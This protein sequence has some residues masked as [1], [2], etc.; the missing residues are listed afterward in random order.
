MSYHYN[1]KEQLD[2]H[3]ENVKNQVILKERELQRLINL[4]EHE[5]V[6]R[7]HKHRKMDEDYEKLSHYIKA[8]GLDLQKALSAESKEDVVRK[9]EIIELKSLIGRANVKREMINEE[10]VD[11]QRLLQRDEK[12]IENIKLLYSHAAKDPLF[13]KKAAK[14]GVNFRIKIAKNG[15]R[16]FVPDFD[17]NYEKLAYMF[18]KMTKSLG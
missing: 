6:Q 8:N 11:A 2:E 12:N 4:H 3:F 5:Q 1:K 7:D 18:D 17:K 14:Y 13:R 15:K 16:M 10:L 9:R